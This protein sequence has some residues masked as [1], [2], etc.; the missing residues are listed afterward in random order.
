MA[1]EP[2]PVIR[3]AIAFIDGQ[4]LYRHAKDAFGHHHPNYDPVKLHRE[5]CRINGWRPTLVRFY[6]GVP[7]PSHNELWSGYWSARVLSLKRAGV[8]VTTRR[9]RYD[10]QTVVTDGREHETITTAQEKGIDV[11]IALDVVRLARLRQYDVCV[12]YSQDNDLG[13][14]VDEVR[15]IAAEQ[16]RWIKLVSAFPSSPTASCSRG[17]NRTDWFK[18]EREVYDACLDARDYRPKLK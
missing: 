5:V 3:N 2:A 15:E 8:H 14:L 9:V 4:N 1:D 7:D 12:I 17:I 16:G 18:I 6:T 11:R 13:E 10:Q